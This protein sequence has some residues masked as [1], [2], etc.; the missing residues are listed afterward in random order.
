MKFMPPEKMA[1]KA[2]LWTSLKYD[3][4]QLCKKTRHDNDVI[5][6]ILIY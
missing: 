4:K 1:V 5:L 6:C 3:Y 2:K